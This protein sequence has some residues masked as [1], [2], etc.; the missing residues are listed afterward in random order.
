MGVR[1]G[2]PVREIFLNI[3]KIVSSKL[4]PL[5]IVI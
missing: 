2:T 5:K 4:N 3:L 1:E